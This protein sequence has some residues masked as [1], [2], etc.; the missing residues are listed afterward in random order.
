[1]LKKFVCST[2]AAMMAV[3]GLISASDTAHGETSGNPSSTVPLKSWYTKPATSW[4][5]EALPL[6]NGFM[7][8]MVFGGVEKDQILINE[9]S[10]WS[11][12]PGANAAYNGGHK[13]TAEYKHD[14]LQKA[15]KQLQDLMTEFSKGTPAYKDANGNV[16]A[17]NYSNPSSLTSL[18]NGVE[19]TETGGLIG[20]KKN[21]GSYQELGSIWLQDLKTA[22]PSITRIYTGQNNT[23]NSSET[24]EKLFDGNTSTKYFADGYAGASEYVIEWDYSKAFTTK[25]Y[26]LTTG[27]DTQGRDPKDWTLS[28]SNDG[29][30]YETIASVTNFVNAG[31]NQT[32]TFELDKPGSYKYFKL[33]VSA[34][35]GS[36]Q[37]LQMSEFT[38]IDDSSVPPDQAVTNYKRELDLNN[39]MA[40]V[41][42]QQGDVLMK[43]EYFVNYPDNVMAIRLSSTGSGKL[44][45]FVSVTS[46]QTKKSISSIGD[47][48]TMT[49]WPSDHDKAGAA[50]NFDNTLHFAQQIKV[51][52]T[53]GK[54]VATNNGV[55]VENA[56]SILILMAA[57]TNYQ[58]SMDDQFKYFT[59]KDPLSAVSARLAAAAEKGFDQLLDRHV[60]DYQHLFDRVKLNLMNVPL[61]NKPTDQLLAGYARSNTSDEDR[62]LEQ[63]Y[64]QF[65]RYLLISSSREGSLPA[66]LQGIWAS[67]T[68]PPWS[69]DY[70]AN[71]NLQ[72][73]YWLA[74]QTN[75]SESHMPLIEYIKSLVPRGTIS[76]QHGYVTP[77]GGPVRGWTTHHENNIWGNTAPATSSAFFSPEDGAW[78]A[79]HIWEHYQFT[80]DEDFLRDNYDILLGAAL[81]WVDTLWED[82]RDGTLVANPSYSPEHGAYSLGATEVQS[83]VWGIFDDVIKASNVLNISSSELNGIKQAQS[84]LAGP[85]IGLGGQFMEW[86]DEVAMDI[87]GDNGHRHTNQ[88]FGLHPGNQIVAGRSEQEDK[89]VEA[90]KVTLNT[91]GDGATGWSKAWKLNFWARL[92]DGDRAQKLLKE[93]LYE[94]TLSNLFDTHPP[95]QIDGNFGATAGMTEMLLQSQGGGIE[96]LPALPS[97]W[98]TGSVS[99]LKARGNVEVDMAWEKSNLKSAV[100]KTGST[101]L[102][103]VKGPNLSTAT[104]KNG[105]QSVD[106]TILDSN[107]IVLQAQKGAVYNFSDIQ[108][109]AISHNPYEVMNAVDADLLYGNITKSSVVLQDANVGDYAM[110]KNVQ[111]GEGGADRVVIQVASTKT[112]PEEL[113]KVELRLD[114]PDGDVVASILVE[115]TGN[116]NVYKALSADLS[117]KVSGTHDLYISFTRP[118]NLKSLQFFTGPAS[119]KITG[120]NV[121]GNTLV[122]LPAAGRRDVAYTASVLYSDGTIQTGSKQVKWNLGG[123]YSGVKLSNDGILS[124]KEGAETQDIT[125]IA[126]SIQDPSKSKQLQVRIV[127]GSIQNLKLRG[128]DRNGESG[129]TNSNG[130]MTFSNDWV[131]FVSSNGW[132]K[133]SNVNLKD[134]LQNV[135]IGY[136]SPTDGTREMQIRVADPGV[137]TVASATTVASLN[138]SAS[139]GGWMNLSEVSTSKV[140]E[141]KGTK[142][143]YLFWPQGNFN[144]SYATLGALV[145]NEIS[146]VYRDVYFD[147]TP[148]DALVTINDAE[149]Y[150]YSPSTDGTTYKLPAGGAY[151][152][153][154]SKPGYTPQTGSFEATKDQ[155]IAV[156]LVSGGAGLSGTHTGST[157]QQF[158]LTYRLNNVQDEVQAQDISI[159]YDPNQLELIAPPV[160]MDDQRVIVA[161]YNKTAGSIRILL[162][163]L[164]V[165]DPQ[166]MGDLLKLSF[167]VK[168]SASAGITTIAI[169]RLITAN[170]SGDESTRS[171]SSHEVQI[172]VIDKS[173]LS[174]LITE[175][176]GVH[177]NAVEGGIAGQY[178]AGS[179]AL[180]QAAIHQAQGVLDNTAATQQ[181]IEQAVST[182]HAALQT[183][184]DSVIQSEPGDMNGDGRVSIGDLAIIAAAYG[185]TSDDPDWSNYKKYDLNNDG[186]IDIED[187][188]VIA[189]KILN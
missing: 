167:R 3:S 131:E 129:G 169:S 84:R 38:V 79:M 175:A 178:P 121:L 134:G 52:P 160:S 185:K 81:F 70:H 32:K 2:L 7:G 11:G 39:G 156:H 58:Q 139:T 30:N 173:V 37:A 64:Y 130:K 31:R 22:K 103:T 126:A 155:T 110:F 90:M 154:V 137:G 177:N 77:A 54:A 164:N 43:K 114:K 143:V 138:M 187:L 96:L 18:I 182:L 63:L 150:L 27:N 168:D 118:S 112:T 48:I 100:L 117:A 152:Y 12:G 33:K 123:S 102:I 9:K 65:G 179:K 127:K 122:S 135:A 87:T 82:T 29:V 97:K 180:L 8:A 162:V 115:N 95:F 67:G 107:T 14:N 47:T 144:L 85:K 73:N 145:A 46:A 153:N 136:A 189:R 51:I 72:M 94:S 20:T 165:A 188:V 21:F 59:G 53:G 6:G 159:S 171:G 98:N 83:V 69:S 184:I 16:I 40:R 86:K 116:L 35:Y 71:I 15:R 49:G 92:R 13:D 108:D 111:F 142:D 105:S 141:V 28:A 55:Q 128:I 62:Y 147:I 104:V 132:L 80:L 42:Y 140:Q 78:L 181:Q 41:S 23:K 57:G 75:L 44:S 124:I 176:Q 50:T 120:I 133:F 66:N 172:S 99:G 119:G 60:S 101:S 148:A 24:I 10:L 158:D 149:G 151:I 106:F 109:S 88:L 34:L 56:D 186:R 25:S 157:G 1:M 36:N 89:Y 93:L 4:E 45:Q 19:S 5:S 174:N 74:E 163:H 170:K 91:R 183:F 76:A 125:V 17:R 61:P 26:S 161:G 146:T 68:N 166:Q 113:G